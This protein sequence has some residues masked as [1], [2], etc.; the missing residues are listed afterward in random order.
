MPLKC[1]VVPNIPFP[2]GIVGDQYELTDP[3]TGIP[4]GI[5]GLELNFDLIFSFVAED[6]TAP[7]ENIKLGV[8]VPGVRLSS[9]S[10]NTV[11]ISG[12]PVLFTN[13]LWQFVFPSGEVRQ[14][15]PINNS[16]YDHIVKWLAPSPTSI[17]HLYQFTVSVGDFLDGT[18][19]GTGKQTIDFSVGQYF[20]WKYEGSLALFESIVEKGKNT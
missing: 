7:I 12:R 1:V 18:Y 13:E 3:P 10:K 15:P 8:G 5:N 16:P 14:L 6:S 17:L 2:Q 19:A 11:N 20:Y 9:K 4:S